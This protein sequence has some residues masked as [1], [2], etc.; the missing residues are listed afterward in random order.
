MNTSNQNIFVYV[1]NYY[2]FKALQKLLLSHVQFILCCTMHINHLCHEC[3]D[4]D[5]MHFFCDIHKL[6]IK[7]DSPYLN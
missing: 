3:E 2:V 7:V 4:I 1:I 5:A 6:T